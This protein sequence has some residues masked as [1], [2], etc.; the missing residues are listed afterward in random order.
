[1]S[2]KQSNRVALVGTA[3]TA[4]LFA[5]NVN[6]QSSNAGDDDLAIE[7][8]T[9]TAE[10]REESLQDV[11][12]SIQAVTGDTLVEQNVVRLDDLDHLVPN[13]FITE[14]LTGNTLNIRGIGTSQGNAGFEQSVATFTDGIYIG[15][16]RQAI[17]PLTDIAQ[18][19]VLR[20]PQPVFFGQSAVAGALNITTRDGRGEFDANVDLTYASDGEVGIIGGVTIPFSET[21]GVRLA[22][23]YTDMDG[24]MTNSFT[25]EDWVGLQTDL[26]RVTA[27]W[28]VTPQFD[29][30][31]RYETGT[32]EQEGTPAELVGCDTTP[33]P[34][35][36]FPIFCQAATNSFG[37]RVEWTY[38]GQTSAGG[39]AQGTIPATPAGSIPI[40]NPQFLDTTRLTETDLVALTWN[41]DFGAATL[42]GI[43]A[44]SEYDFQ[45]AA[46]IGSTP[47]AEIHPQL[48]ETYE[49]TSHEIRL[50]SNEPA[51]DGFL[52]YM[53]GFYYQDTETA[54]LNDT[55]TTFAL[56]FGAPVETINRGQWRSDDTWT[57]LFASFTG[58]FSDSFRTTIGLRY[59]DVE[60]EGGAFVSSAPFNAAGATA[61]FMA[62]SADPFVCDDDGN[63]DGFVQNVCELGSI[64]TDDLGGQVAFEWD[65]NDSVMWF[66]TYTDA[67]KAGGLSQVLRGI[68]SQQGAFL[69]DDEESTSVELGFK[70]LL[71]DSRLRLNANLFNT[72]FNDLQ[73]S[74][75]DVAT[76]SFNVENAAEATSTGLE[77]DGEFLATENLTITF[78]GSFLDA[79]Y[80]SF[81]GAQ[82]SQFEQ[83][84]GGVDCYFGPPNPA[85]PNGTGGTTD[86]AGFPLLFA[87]DFTFNVGARY[88]VA[89]SQNLQLALSGNLNYSDEYDVSDRY[90]P[91][92]TDD[93]GF[94]GIQSAVERLD[95]RVELLDADGTWSVAVFGNNVTDERP[96]TLFG[97]SQFNGVSA[98]FA[99]GT[100][101]DVYGVQVRARFGE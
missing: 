57:S 41:Y 87:P 39:A 58:N 83:G 3:F 6:G 12:L 54:T 77:F 75:F 51:F 97:P 30:E 52:D 72:E 31:L 49:Q 67:F 25:G 22:G 19:E 27:N 4:F 50:A 11:S 91:R 28:D 64:D 24:W 65:Q 95:L 29:V 37:D 92:N 62:A 36:P 7:V 45:G 23:R 73:V 40:T 78:S 60:K 26:V 66:L 1:M 85:D 53:I 48:T 46:D 8:I 18:V 17:A 89:V 35:P 55:L 70:S 80:D 79:E 44:L 13:L 100:R 74:S 81:P 93:D 61:P 2:F 20:G 76:N 94:G 82:C 47:F 14:G 101:G 38:D 33:V 99:G 42:S 21:F 15:R 32:S 9:V 69:F 59:S 71:F 84:Q 98:G 43:S 86:R 63:G 96:L 34:G 90:D 68:A 5:T 16:G 88:T 10:K 56:Q